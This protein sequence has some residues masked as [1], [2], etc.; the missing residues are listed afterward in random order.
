MLNLRVALNTPVFGLYRNANRT[1]MFSTLTRVLFGDGS[2]WSQIEQY[3]IN[4]LT[5]VS[6]KLHRIWQ[7][8]S[9]VVF[10]ADVYF[11]FTLKK[12]SKLDKNILSNLW[13]KGLDL[14]CIRLRTE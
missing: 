10:E 11:E 6:V 4:F 2:F 1:L 14:T 13:F 5:C 9:H 7:F 3:G 12:F 8:V